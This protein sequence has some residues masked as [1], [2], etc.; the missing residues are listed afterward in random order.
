MRSLICKLQPPSSQASDAKTADGPLAKTAEERRL[1]QVKALKDKFQRITETE[2]GLVKKVQGVHRGEGTLLFT[3]SPRSTLG[4]KSLF[5]DGD[6][7]GEYARAEGLVR[8]GDQQRGIAVTLDQH[9]RRLTASSPD[10][11]RESITK[12]GQISG[13]FR[14]AIAAYSAANA[15][16][17]DIEKRNPKYAKSLWYLLK[18]NKGR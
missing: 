5:G 11:V 17:R 10:E 15:A 4:R 12:V 18:G 7:A 14:K 9:F 3:Q 13:A 16:Y 6:E 2:A 1:E 8:T